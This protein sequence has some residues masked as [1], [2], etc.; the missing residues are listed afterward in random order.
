MLRS[1]VLCAPFLILAGKLPANQPAP[2]SGSRFDRQLAAPVTAKWDNVSFRHAIDGLKDAQKIA[3]VTDRRIDADAPFALTVEGDSLELTLARIAERKQIGCTIFPPVIYFGPKSSCARLQTLAALRREE[4][5]KL[6][7]GP[8]KLMAHSG[9]GGWPSLA[10]PARLVEQLAAEAK[11]TVTNLEAIPHDLWAESRLPSMPWSD[12]LTLIL[13]QFDLT[14]D[15]APNGRAI[16]LTPI[17]ADVAITKIYAGGDSPSTRQARLQKLVPNA[18][19]KING[20]QIVVH[21]RVEDHHEI[22]TLLAGKQVRTKTVTRGQ[23]RYTLNVAGLPLESVLAQLGQMLKLEIKYDRAAID[24]ADGSLEQLISF[25]VTD[26]TL[27][28]L[29]AAALKGTGLAYELAGKTVTIRP[30]K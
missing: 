24:K 13:A 1:V 2:N 10:E 17:P 5:G 12:R 30:A 21:G 4:I 7:A 11:L 22:A 23:Q 6:Q 26:A 27:D 29:L 18:Q 16:T 15:I 3:I 14:F 25:K 20:K 8:R 19:I 28:E 9:P